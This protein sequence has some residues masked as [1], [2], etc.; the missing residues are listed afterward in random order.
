MP[1]RLEAKKKHTRWS[2]FFPNNADVPKLKCVLRQVIERGA[3]K[4]IL[5]DVSAC[6]VDCVWPKAVTYDSAARLVNL[7]KKM[8][9]SFDVLGL[10]KP[11][12]GELDISEGEEEVAEPERKRSLVDTP[13][14]APRDKQAKAVPAA[15]KSQPASQGAT[16]AASATAL[17]SPLAVASGLARPPLQTA[18]AWLPPPRLLCLKALTAK[19][20]LKDSQ[21][22]Y[23]SHKYK[24]TCGK[25]LGSGTYGDVYAGVSR[26]A[27][28]QQVAIKVCNG[29]VMREVTLL[30]AVSP[31]PHIITLVDVGLFQLNKRRLHQPALG[32]VFEAFDVDLRK[33]LHRQPLRSAGMRHVL[34]SVLKALAY[35]HERGLVHADLKPANI[36]LRGVGDFQR[37]FR[38]LLKTGANA[39]ARVPPAAASASSAA[40]SSVADRTIEDKNIEVD[41]ANHLPWC[42]EVGA[43]PQM[44]GIGPF[45]FE[46]PGHARRD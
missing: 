36:L 28:P 31:H 17:A 11:V 44:S 32:L 16:Q 20:R 37:G 7:A 34:R 43:R 40:S 45:F 4:V 27:V 8:D 6:R 42:F 18:L 14:G 22:G 13:G 30:C 39:E 15:D 21:S 2:Y 26:G 25:P 46:V 38:K 29:D 19:D 1:T 35:V 23:D 41:L 5:H 3:A 9:A 12:T 24:I 33:F 10:P